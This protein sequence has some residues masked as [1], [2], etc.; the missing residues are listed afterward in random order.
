MN[1]TTELTATGTAGAIVVGTGMKKSLENT[2]SLLD[3]TLTQILS[4][5]FILYGSDITT[6]I[7]SI[8]LI[9]NFII[10]YRKFL[11]EKQTMKLESAN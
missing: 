8:F 11:K 7:G 9:G 2:Q 1:Q 10:G 6:V 4:G 3:S 5:D